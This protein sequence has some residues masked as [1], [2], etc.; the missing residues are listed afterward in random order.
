MKRHS[1]L[2]AALIGLSLLTAAVPGYA[3]DLP[4]YFDWR[5]SAPTD[6]SSATSTAIVGAIRDQGYYGLCWA[7]GTMAS[8]ESSFNIK[9][10][11]AG[12]APIAPLSER[13]LGWLVYNKPLNGGGDG[14]IYYHT[15]NPNNP[16]NHWGGDFVCQSIGVLARYP[17]AY[18]SEYPYVE[19]HQIV[20]I[21]EGVNLVA[22]RGIALHD[23]YGFI[24]LDWSGED[25]S[26]Y[27]VA[28]NLNTHIDYYKT[29]LQQY[30]ILRVN[31]YSDAHTAEDIVKKG[32][33]HTT[34][35]VANHGV[36]LVGWDDDYIMTTKDGVSHKGAWLLRNTWGTSVSGFPVGENGYYYLSYDDVTAI[37]PVFYNG[38]TDW[39]RYTAV[40]TIAPGGVDPW[41]NENGVLSWPLTQTGGYKVADKLTS[42]GSQ[43]LK[44][45][46]IY[47]PADS[48]SY[49]VEVSLKGTTP[50]DTQAI[51]TKT[52]TFGQD[53]TAIYKGYRTIDFDKYVYLPKG[54]NY[55]VT[56]T[57]TGKSGETYTVPMSGFGQGESY[58]TAASYVY[59][60]QTGTWA[61]V[62][63]M[64]H[65]P[66]DSDYD[67]AV[68]MNAL[69]KYS[70]EANGGDFTVVSL[71]D[72][73]AGGS[74]IYL[75]KK[76]ELYTLDLLHPVVLNADGTYSAT[77]TP[78][79]TLSNMTV[80]LTKDITDSVY[81]GVISGEGQVIK[82]GTGMLA[83]S[84][85]NT[86]TGNTN[87][88]E[89]SFALTGS[90]Q[91]HV[92]IDKGATFTGN[93]TI[94]GNLT[95]GGTLQPGLNADAVNLLNTAA[96][97][98]G[99]TT[100][101]QVGTLTVQGNLTSNGK[102][103]ISANNTNTSK[104][105]VSGSSALTGTTLSVANGGTYPLINHIYNYLTSQGGIIGNVT[106]ETNSPYLTLQA[107][108]AGNNGYFT[109]ANTTKLGNQ[110]GTTP[111]EN[112]VGSVLQNKAMGAINADPTSANAQAFNSLFYQDSATAGKFIK[113][114][115]SEARAALLNKSPMSSLTNES[116]FSRLDTVDFNGDVAV[117]A[118][119][120]LDAN[121]PEMKTSLPV[122][123]DATNNVWFK[124]FR[125]FENYNYNDSLENK[126]FGGAVG[127]DHALNLNTRIGGLFSY[128]VTDYNTDNI[129]GKS[130][131]W[132]VG[133]Y[134]SHKSGDWDYQALATYGRNHYD[135]DRSVTYEG[136]KTN[137]DYKAKVW[138]GEVKARYF[139][140]STQTRTWQVKPYGKVSYTHTAQDA[141][142]ETGTSTFKQNL[143]SASNNS[144][145]GEV[146]VELNRN[147]NNK[148]SWGGSVGYKRVL[149]GL[150]PE[151]N[152]T[153]VGDTNVF[154]I[155]SDNDRNYVTYSLNAR[156]SLG[157]KWMGQAE[158]RGEASSN[159]HKEILSVTAK[160]SF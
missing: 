76:N 4:T 123:L 115:T 140:P 84:G 159:T 101:S 153:F 77:G 34:F 5:R 92:T 146:G 6:R 22:G 91:S 89:G 64:L 16:L 81:G 80:D 17:V 107:T 26:K 14:F 121:A 145:R 2:L 10:Q 151:L 131:D 61:D 39:G 144:W 19:P 62:H 15:V 129:E 46:G 132:R 119:Q 102:L 133:V 42:G 68:P 113:D 114:M 127:Y 120:S 137:S 30:G 142:A 28:I 63:D 44:A 98:S 87:V 31:Y 53:G 13:S 67:T 100:A 24:P 18:A 118:A 47:V 108:V 50:A 160:Y 29:M 148:T 97:G 83:L 70:N 8:L 86:Y 154:T 109:A 33:C 117:N 147:L 66:F 55:F 138:D 20:H 40:D 122:T 104:L 88:Q 73:G 9:L 93:G 103:V 11:A 59:D 52:G 12:L 41:N 51:Y 99:T 95:N 37:Y 139:I 135:L 43:M 141:Y 156:G 79:Y 74:E 48:M 128:G 94:N 78:R 21:M 75:G 27:F 35:N 7:F 96:G 125:G 71:N 112:S 72:N 1:K 45:V 60:T 158:F 38:E 54:Q 105:A 155:R 124:L 152:G 25:E 149:S 56:V 136:T 82:T 126:S 3:S 23:A 90:L 110:Q 36:S 157:G 130:Y 49:K 106:S 134:G 32:I 116:I 111:S 143:N 65:A 69:N 57:L 85:A 58:P 150:N